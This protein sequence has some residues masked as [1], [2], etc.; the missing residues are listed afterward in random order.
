MKKNVIISI[1]VPVYNAKHNL[2]RC[3]ESILNQ[4]FQDFE[5]ILVND[6]SKD[7][8][9][10][11]CKEFEKQDKRITVIDK[12]NGGVSSARNAG[13][14]LIRGKYVMFCDSDDIIHPQ[15]CELLLAAYTKNTLVMCKDETF[16]DDRALRINTKD[17]NE[18]EEYSYIS[19]KDF[20]FHQSDGV[21][22]PVLKIYESSIIKEYNLRF[23]VELSLGEDLSF[24]LQYLSVI[25]G[26]IK[27]LDK[28]LYFYRV[29]DTETLSKKAP[30]LEQCELFNSVL[31]KYLYDFGQKN[32]EAWILKS[33]IMMY[34]YEKTIRKNIEGK[35]LSIIEKYHI[36]YRIMNSSAYKECCKNGHISS[37]KVYSFLLSRRC[38]WLLTLFIIFNDRRK[39]NY[40]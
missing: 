33:K 26:E 1:I 39:R 13:L 16:Y 6:G 40:K 14:K 27:V 7:E 30:S 36:V 10:D 18:T 21:W 3:I 25:K 24:I 5:L 17:K 2:H 35:R 8:S 29:D 31:N 15:W 12:E 11:I 22:S 4:S 38:A 23:P 9:L 34:N 28:V 37:N 32:Q 19:K 20:I